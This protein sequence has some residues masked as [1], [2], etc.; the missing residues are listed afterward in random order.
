MSQTNKPLPMGHPNKPTESDEIFVGIMKLS[1]MLGRDACTIRKYVADGKI[2]PPV[3]VDPPMW[4]RDQFTADA[5]MRWR[6][7]KAR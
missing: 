7:S 5:M 2:P 4:H 6:M 1:R 3:M